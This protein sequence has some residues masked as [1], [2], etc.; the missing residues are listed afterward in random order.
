MI[1]LRLLL[2]DEN[3]DEE[4]NELGTSGACPSPTGDSYCGEWSYSLELMDEYDLDGEVGKRLT[5]MVPIPV[6]VASLCSTCFRHLRVP[7][8]ILCLLSVN[9]N[10]YTRFGRFM[11]CFVIK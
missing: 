6:S 2:G 5:Q 8:Y 7:H 9:M 10:M 4:E 11:V 1:V 3:G